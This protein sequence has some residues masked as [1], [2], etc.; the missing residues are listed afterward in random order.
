M[1]LIP[2]QTNSR[3]LTTTGRVIIIGIGAVAGLGIGVIVSVTTS[4]SFTEAIGAA[5]GAGLAY[6]ATRLWI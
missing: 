3:M 6:V 4:L 5:I 1:R 2:E